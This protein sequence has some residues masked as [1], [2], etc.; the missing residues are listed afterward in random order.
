[1]IMVKGPK[2]QRFKGLGSEFASAVSYGGT[3]SVQGFKG[4]R[5]LEVRQSGNYAVTI[6]FLSSNR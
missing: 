2:V 6:S 4:S 3:S 5:L 1:M